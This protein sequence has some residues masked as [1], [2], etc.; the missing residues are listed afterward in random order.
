MHYLSG[1]PY[2]LDIV[3]SSRVSVRGEGLTLVPVNRVAK[4]EVDTQ[5][6]TSGRVQVEITGKHRTV[7]TVA[8][9]HGTYMSAVL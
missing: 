4:F 6:S 5:G 7:A 2:T 1:S 9:R 8:V 3:D